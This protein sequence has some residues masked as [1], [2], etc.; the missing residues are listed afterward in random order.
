[1][2]PRNSC[3]GGFQIQ[4]TPESPIE[5]TTHVGRVLCHSLFMSISPFLVTDETSGVWRIRH[6]GNE[7]T[8]MLETRRV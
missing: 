8:G 7:R 2:I 4:I 1:M 6:Q 5:C 3:K